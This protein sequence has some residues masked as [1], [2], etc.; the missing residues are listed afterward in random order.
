M[1][2]KT[3][4][5]KI[6]PGYYDLIY[7]KKKGIQSAWHHVKFNFVK[8]E[9]DKKLVHLDIGCGPGTFVGLLEKTKS[10]GIDI[11]SN[12]INYAKKNYR[13]KSKFFYTYK[14]KIPLK[15]KSIDFISLVELIEHLD[16]KELSLLLNECKRVLKKDGKI[17]FTTPN[18]FSFWPVLEIILNFISPFS[19]KHQHINKFNKKRLF[20]FLNS[21]NFNVIKTGTFILIAPFLAPLSFKLSLFL[22]KIDNFLCKFFPGFLLYAIVKNKN[23]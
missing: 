17:L 11:S 9:I 23:I 3:N 15:N 13:N 20:M 2:I 14:K 18:Y 22:G 6:I 8:H 7:K 10:I 5:N 1:K 19:Y 4:Y 16:N 12:Q 21:Q